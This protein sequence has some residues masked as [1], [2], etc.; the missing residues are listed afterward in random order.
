MCILK[1]K[2]EENCT[3]IK[4]YFQVDE[5]DLEIANRGSFKNSQYVAVEP[6]LD[7]EFEKYNSNYGWEGKE[8]FLNT[9]TH[10]S[11]VSSSG[12]FMVC[13]LQGNVGIYIFDPIINRP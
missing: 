8:D 7:G 9:L 3:A 11:Y 10:W 2:P 5:T 4:L 12:N 13:D 6:F 1:K